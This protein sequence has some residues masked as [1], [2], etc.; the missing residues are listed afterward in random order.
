VP[1]A[2]AAAAV[3]ASVWAFEPSPHN[4]AW[5]RRNV[6]LNGLAGTVTIRETGLGDRDAELTLVSGEYGVGNAALEIECKPLA[7]HELR[8]PEK[9]PSVQV[10]VERL[11]DVDLPAPISVVKIDTEGFEAAFLRGGSERLA[12]D[13]PVIFGEFSPYWLRQRG[14][15]LRPLLADSGYRAVSLVGV[16]SRRWRQIDTQLEQ[17]VDLAGEGPLPGNLLLVPDG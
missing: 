14:E 6:E 17:R 13:R 12:R 11:D 15:E 1:L 8:R 4:T 9:F 3:G 5:I 2:R 16:R 7:T 10:R